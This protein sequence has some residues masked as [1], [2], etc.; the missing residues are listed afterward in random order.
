MVRRALLGALLLSCNVESKAGDTGGVALGDAGACPAALAMISSD[1]SS[2][3]LSVLD[4]DG[5]VVSASVLSSGS[6]PVGISQVLSGDV[7]LPQDRQ[8]A[9]IV[10]IDR[11]PNAVL[12]FIDRTSGAIEGQMSVATGF[13]SNPHDYLS[14]S[15]GRAYVTRYG[16]NGN[17][18]KEP[19]DTGSDVLIIDPQSRTIKGSVPFPKQGALLPRPDRML[20]LPQHNQVWVTLQRF[21]VNFRELGDSELAAIDTRNDALRWIVPLPGARNCGAMALSPSGRYAVVACSGPLIDNRT[22]TAGSMLVVLDTAT[23]SDLDSVFAQGVAFANENTVVGTT[24]GDKVSGKTDRIFVANID[25]G[26]QRMAYDTKSAFVLG[27]NVRCLGA[28]ADRCFV[29]DAAQGLLH[30]VRADGSIERTVPGAAAF[31]LPPRSLGLL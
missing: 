14:L 30:V 21:N 15:P 26:A 13:P 1:R 7:V 20:A 5:K 8:S 3:N 29:P 22:N 18:G 23:S 9:N 11:F 12:T 4:L 28:C 27:D 25:T 16:D 19:F 6:R 17:A 31:G 24:Y 2:S 10:L